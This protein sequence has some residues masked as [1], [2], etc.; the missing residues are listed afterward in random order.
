MSDIVSS[1]SSQTGVSPDLVRKGLGAVLKML[2]DQLPPELFSKVQGVL[3]DAGTMISASE[4]TAPEAGGM[5]QAVTSL[6]GKLFG[7]RGEAATDLFTRLG[8]HGFS[9]DQLKVFLPKVLEFFK[10]K[11]PPEVLGMV[12]KLVP[13][14]S[15][16]AGTTE[17]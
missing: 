11:L 4:S 10:D 15:E 13:G 14:L 17:S 7:N 6:A 8:Q 3:P 12:E 1:L 9:P 16:V 5:I 2:Q